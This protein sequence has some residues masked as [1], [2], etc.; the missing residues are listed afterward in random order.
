MRDET[1]FESAALDRFRMQ[2]WDT[3]SATKGIANRVMHRDIC[4]LQ[5]SKLLRLGYVGSD[6]VLSSDTSNDGSQPQA[7]IG[8][9]EMLVYV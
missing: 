6:R 3:Q 1:F 9:A 8:N 5:A 7:V 2:I 4:F